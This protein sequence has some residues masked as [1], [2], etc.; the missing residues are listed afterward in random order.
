MGRN[1][2]RDER[3]DT[4]VTVMSNDPFASSAAGGRAASGKQPFWRWLFMAGMKRKK[5]LIHSTHL[6]SIMQPLSQLHPKVKDKA[7][8][9]APAK[10]NMFEVVIMIS[11]NHQGEGNQRLGWCWLVS[12]HQRKTNPLLSPKYRCNYKSLQGSEIITTWS[13]NQWLFI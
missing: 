10:L 1:E 6:Q 4:L 13:S 9:F 3:C 2:C 11:K 5:T 7:V 12:F 8:L